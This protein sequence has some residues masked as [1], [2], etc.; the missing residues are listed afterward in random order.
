MNPPYRIAETP[1]PVNLGSHRAIVRVEEAAPAVLARIPWRRQDL[2][3]ELKDIVIVDAT[4]QTLVRN[5]LPRA[6]RQESGDILFQPATTPG[7]YEIYYLPFNAAPS[8]GMGQNAGDHKSPENTAEPAWIGR[9]ET[10]DAFP[11]PETAVLEI[12]ARTPMDSVHPMGLIATAAETQALVE[13]HAGEPFLLFPT[14]RELPIRMK[15]HLPFHWIQCGPS[16]IFRGEACR[17]EFFVFQ[18]GVFAPTRSLATLSVS[19][20][21]LRDTQTDAAI[22]ASSLQCFNLGGVDRHGVPFRKNVAVPRGKIQALWFGVDVPADMTAG[23]YTGTVKIQADDAPP[24]TIEIQLTV[25]PKTLAD[26]GDREPSRHSRLRWLNST[27]ALDED[28][29][30]PFTPLKWKGRNLRCLDRSLTLGNN[31]LPVAIQSRKKKI[32]ESPIRFAI[33]IGDTEHDFKKGDLRF[34]EQSA[35]RIAWESSS[36]ADAFSFHCRGSMEFD[37]FVKFQ[38]SLRVERDIEADDIRLEIPLRRDIA[39]YM[40]GLGLRGGRRPERW[41]WRWDRSAHQDSVW[42]GTMNA[43]LYCQ[44]LD[45]T[46]RQASKIKYSV[47]PLA[48][49]RAWNN[50]GK[51][52]CVITEVD[53]DC[54]L[55]AFGTGPRKLAPGDDLRLDFNLMITPFKRLDTATHF[56]TRYFHSDR[57]VEEAVA[58]GCTVLNIHHATPINRFINYPFLDAGRLRA[59]ATAAHE[60]GLKMKIYYTVRELTNH[61][62]ELWALRSLGDEIFAGGDGGGHAWLRENIVRDYTPIWYN[63]FEDGSVDASLMQ[64]P[65]SRWH[66]FYLEGLAWLARE[67]RMDGLYLD[68]TDL[69]RVGLQRAHK[70]MARERPGSMVDMH[71]ADLNWAMF[72]MASCTQLYMP[73]LPYVDRLWVG[74][75][76]EFSRTPPDYWLVELS[77]IPFGVMADLLFCELPANPWRGALF[78]MTLRVPNGSGVNDPR[79]IWKCWDEFGIADTRMIGWWEEDCPVRT[80]HKD[81]RAT[82]Y[83]GKNR[84]LVAVASWAERPV[85]V[86]LEVDWK[87][88][89]LKRAKTL[90]RAP[91]IEH[92]QEF[93]TFRPVDEIPVRPQRGWMFILE[94]SPKP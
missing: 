56:R 80:S 85:R 39:T 72:G 57:P 47:R 12:Q 4:T 83:V 32:L 93:A 23:I 62:P 1:W 67:T 58:S 40:M 27:I 77:G 60:R 37:G 2:S 20:T 19:F 5:R 68:D 18:I 38:V 21:D 50:D 91:R 43:G 55:V 45:E 7:T 10:P 28:V 66:N 70:I 59:H 87:A 92:F 63:P 82:A 84:T 22:P 53:A 17:N 48:M 30:P 73:L 3:P 61:A 75:S 89:G 25:I 33:R 24:R 11:L 6:I 16:A 31:A 65:A 79:P 52:G 46:Y 54:V 15:D 49:P 51:G 81:V 13:A 86:K 35:A 94:H 64:S 88:L 36:K 78:G 90:L 74:E 14:P 34:L 44:L 41:H 9:W 29:P 69:D 76:F 8:W 26:R 42:I 71:S